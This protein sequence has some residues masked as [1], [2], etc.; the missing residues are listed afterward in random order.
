MSTTT[1]RTLRRICLI[2]LCVMAV[3]QVSARPRQSEDLFYAF[4]PVIT[5][6]L[7]PPATESRYLVVASMQRTEDY[8]CKQGQAM[9]AGQ[10]S[11]V[12]LLYRM[13]AYEPAEQTYGTILP[14][15][16]RVF[17][18]TVAISQSAE[19]WVEGFWKCNSSQ[20]TKITLAIGT[21]NFDLTPELAVPHAKAWVTMVNDVSEYVQQHGFGAAITIAAASN[22]ELNW[23]TPEA[24]RAW[25]ESYNDAARLWLY[26]LGDCSG[27]P[28]SFNPDWL[29]DN[30]WT[31]EDLWYISWGVFRAYQLPEIYNTRGVAAS[32]WQFVARWGVDHRQRLMRFFSPVTQYQACLDHPSSSCAGKDNRPEQGWKQLWNALNS[33][34]STA[35]NIGWLTD[36]RW[37]Y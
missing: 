21:S 20:N 7:P 6:P 28:S 1:A 12:V 11:I 13:P 8:G 25:V 24:A 27:C 37:N 35:Q 23:S 5:T 16:R 29:P 30:G 32:Q 33:D 22:I 15:A 4:L 18:S 26:I 2:V 34:P 31:T 36:L 10:N 14:D 3:A 9:Q 17:T 19:R